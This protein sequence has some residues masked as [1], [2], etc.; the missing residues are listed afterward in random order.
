VYL[1]YFLHEQVSRAV[2]HIQAGDELDF[3][4]KVPLDIKHNGKKIIVLSDNGTAKI[5]SFL[6]RDYTIDSITAEYIVAWKKK[7]EES[8]CR[9]ILPVIQLSRS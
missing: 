6:D 7:E 1:D 3:V 9:V 8:R 4:A 5:K 2:N